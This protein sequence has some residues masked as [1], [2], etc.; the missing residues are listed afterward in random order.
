M[1]LFNWISTG[2]W[3]IVQTDVPQGTQCLCDNP[4]GSAF[5]EEE[6][7]A[8][9]AHPID[10]EAATNVNLQ[11]WAK[12]S[13]DLYNHYVALCY[14]SGGESY[15]QTIYSFMGVGD[16]EHYDLDL[17]A[18]AG[19][20]I[21][22]SFSS[23]GIWGVN[24]ATFW[25]DDIHLYTDNSYSEAQYLLSPPLRVLSSPNPFTR[26]LAIAVQGFEKGPLQLDIYNIRGQKV[27][28]K[29]TN[30]L[31]SPAFSLNWNVLD[32]A[33]REPAAGVYILKVSAPNRETTIRKI[34]K[35]H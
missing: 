3:D 2:C 19:Q 4:S 33:G 7:S 14:R 22:L 26:E 11:F 27:C 9:Y 21:E 29:K 24:Y 8:T 5:Y 25:I 13:I 17:S 6:S 12:K 20:S 35:L 23:R 15:W 28:S 34:L 32:K 31:T 18:L 1:T 10:L 16:W 30:P